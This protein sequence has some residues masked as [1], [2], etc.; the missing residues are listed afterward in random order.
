MILWIKKLN[1][2]NIAYD[3]RKQIKAD[4]GTLYIPAQKSYFRNNKMK[5][6]C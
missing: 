1:L 5:I 6:D 3:L 2:K 4:K